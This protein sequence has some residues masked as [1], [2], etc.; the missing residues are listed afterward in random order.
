MKTLFD[1]RTPIPL[2]RHLT[3]H[4]VD[5][6]F[7]LGWSGLEN[8]KLLDATEQDGYSRLPWTGSDLATM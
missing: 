3:G 8:G 5:T 1:Q 2:R 7:E 4:I 6:A